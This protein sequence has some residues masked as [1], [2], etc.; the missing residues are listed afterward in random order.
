MQARSRLRVVTLAALLAGSARAAPAAT[1]ESA[2]FY[3]SP[4]GR[5]TWSGRLAAANDTGDDGPF[6]SFAR[7]QQAVRDLMRSG[8]T[9]PV[10]VLFRGGTY[11]LSEPIT[12]RPANSGTARAPV[13]YAA[14]PGETPVFSGGRKITTEWTRRDDGVWTTKVKTTKHYDWFFRQLFVHGRRAVRART[15]TNGFLRTEGPMPGLDPKDKDRYD[16]RSRQGFRIKPGDMR[17]WHNF[18]DVN[19]IVYHSW[20]TSLHWIDSLDETSQVV[21]FTNK[22]GWPF[23]FFEE[24]QR[25]FIENCRE[26]LDAPGEW[27]LDR[28]AGT[29]A[30]MPHEGQNVPEADTS[31]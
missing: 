20:T 6:A 28:W 7:A 15:P 8:R 18:G 16:D 13:I 24:K 5:D 22:S 21:R 29:L 25:Y 12:F 1:K 10:T 2:D 3:V 17:Q 23:S 4:E 19:V 26:A 31:A 30:Y 9:K 11:W 14:Y 27:Y